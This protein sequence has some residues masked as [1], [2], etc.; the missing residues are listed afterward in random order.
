ML[1]VS[2]ILGCSTYLYIQSHVIF[3]KDIYKKIQKRGKILLKE[4]IL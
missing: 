1:T 2:L 3:Q 4:I